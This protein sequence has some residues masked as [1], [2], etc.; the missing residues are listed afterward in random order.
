MVFGLF[1]VS[2]GFV[3]RRHYLYFH[4]YL[5]TCIDRK[6]EETSSVPKPAIAR[7]NSRESRDNED[8]HPGR[9]AFG[10]AAESLDSPGHGWPKRSNR[11]AVRTRLAF[12]RSLEPRRSAVSPSARPYECRHSAIHSRGRQDSNPRRLVR[13]P[14][15]LEGP[16]PERQQKPGWS[17]VAVRQNATDWGEPQNK[18]SAGRIGYVS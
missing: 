6:Q 14:S 15:Q 5:K 9:N 16:A 17:A 3:R 13:L 7:S 8:D 18:Q 11:R 2:F 12:H 10:N 1:F 4:D